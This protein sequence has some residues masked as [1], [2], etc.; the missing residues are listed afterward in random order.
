MLHVAN[1]LSNVFTAI[2][3]L[4]GLGIFGGKL[5]RRLDMLTQLPDKVDALTVQVES[6]KDETA[7]HG[8]QIETLDRRVESRGRR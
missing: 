2:T 6:L 8:Y 3:L 7:R 4:I 5:F 1:A